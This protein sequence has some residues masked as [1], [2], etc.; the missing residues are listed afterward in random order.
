[1]RQRVFSMLAIGAALSAA[2]CD[3]QHQ[4][5]F[6]ANPAVRQSLASTSLRESPRASPPTDVAFVSDV[7]DR[8]INIYDFPAIGRPIRS[9]S[10]LAYAPCSNSAGDVWIAGD[11]NGKVEML[12]Y[13]HDGT[14]PIDH[15]VSATTGPYSCAVDPTSGNLAVASYTAASRSG[16][17]TVYRNAK[18]AGRVY[19]DPNIAAFAYCAYDSKGNL[20]GQGYPS[21]SKSFDVFAELVKGGKQLHDV[22]FGGDVGSPGGVQWDGSYF[23]IGYGGGQQLLRYSIRRFKATFVGQTPLKAGGFG[24]SSFAIQGNTAVAVMSADNGGYGIAT[25]V[26][27]RGSR[28]KHHHLIGTSAG[29]TV[30]VGSSK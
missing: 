29:V 26:Y 7:E 24:L 23:V 9:I 20:L 3:G 8:T 1:M 16:S 5:A 27:P 30:S 18:G 4:T 11:Y 14:G 13:R 6:S 25:F 2:A 28:G 10:G 12:E 15:L 19:F 17:L 22:D 21:G